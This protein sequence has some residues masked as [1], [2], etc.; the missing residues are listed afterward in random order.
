[1]AD[2]LED[3][4][5]LFDGAG[6]LLH[7]NPPAQA[8]LAPIEP[9]IP[10]QVPAW[11]QNCAP[12][13]T[14]AERPA[15]LP[16]A[17]QPL[18][19]ALQGDSLRHQG[20][21]CAAG[22]DAIPVALELTAKPLRNANPRQLTGVLIR[23]HWLEVRAA[24]ARG[25]PARQ[26]TA[27]A[28]PPFSREFLCRLL[29]ALP[30][31]LSVAEYGADQ[32]SARVVYVNSASLSITG[33]SLDE[34]LG[35]P[36]RLLHEDL[37][38]TLPA[39]EFD[40][41]RA[42]CRDGRQFE[43]RLP[44]KRKDGS[45][46]WNYTRLTSLRDDQG[47]VSHLLAL[48]DDISSVIKADT[49]LRW[50]RDQLRRVIEHLPAIFFAVG[51]QGD[52]RLFNQQL[53]A[54][55]GYERDDIRHMTLFDFF[56]GRSREE[57]DQAVATAFAKGLDF[58]LDL[59][60]ISHVGEQIPLTLYGAVA[61][62]GDTDPVLI[63]IALD[64]S[65]VRD[66]LRAS[67]ISE[68][69]LNR[70]QAFANIGL[71]DWNLRND[72]VYWSDRVPELIGST[73]SRMQFGFQEFLAAAHPLDRARLA[74]S[75]ENCVSGHD[76]LDEE[77]RIHRP[78]GSERWMLARANLIYDD[79][80]TPVRMLG[81]VQDITPLK[82]AEFIEKRAREEIQSI[83]DS[84]DAR[85]C[86]VDE[87]GEIISV[88]RSWQRHPY[89][90]PTRARSLASGGNYL[91]FC[92]SLA[93]AGR[94]DMARL[95][96]AVRSVL[97][98]T[99]GT[100]ETEIRVADDERDE[101]HLV[102][103]TPLR[104][105]SGEHPRVVINHTDVT[106]RRQIERDLRQAKDEAEQASR[107]KSEFLSLMSHE[108][109]TPMNAVLGF[110]QLLEQDEELNADQL[111]SVD[112]IL[113]AGRH[114][115]HLINEVL[116]LARVE[117]G[118]VT[119]DAE[120]IA[121]SDLVDECLPL[122]E[123]GA[124]QNDIRIKVG[125]MGRTGVIADRIRLKQVL[126]NLLSNAVKYNS[127]GGSVRIEAHDVEP[128][129][130]AATL[131]ET[132]VGETTVGEDADAK[133]P[134]V[135]IE[136]ID[137]G[138]GIAPEDIAGLFTP[139]SRLE[140]DTHREGTGIGLAVCRRLIEA[141]GGAI[142]ATS[143]LG[144]GSCFW[145]ELE[146]ARLAPEPQGSAPVR[147]SEH[148]LPR[149]PASLQ[150]IL[151]IEDNPSNLKLIERMLGRYASLRVISATNGAEGIELARRE[152]PDLILLDIHMAGMDGYEVF[153]RLRA[154]SRTSAIPV[155]AVTANATAEDI[156]QGNQAGFDAYLTKPVELPTL[157]EAMRRLMA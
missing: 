3:A 39:A 113:K 80:A 6:L 137:T 116:D 81:V 34:F 132:T 153:R 30:S 62:P 11:L 48:Q 43:V 124:R 54:V 90:H 130:M 73:V 5:L 118:R 109:R 97:Q 47:R 58:N 135:R 128:Q 71:W 10:G 119:L 69:R 31:G 36:C 89:R 92:D 24:R 133:E 138:L 18:A 8:L 77:F 26:A 134:R 125:S 156:A 142:G 115:L 136:V 88:N 14:P 122:V 35:H 64:V 85:I 9:P 51:A 78:D 16:A 103:I 106:R 123:A 107:A 93:E 101:I 105:A 145:M 126:I 22:P 41:L 55:S 40:E 50:E 129:K 131:A 155:I 75:I 53:C 95:A 87:N 117:S 1:L 29:E 67:A 147:E 42:A 37:S 56:A 38:A 102:R 82:H 72:E 79:R 99:A 59:P 104:G 49:R 52:F 44:D 70:S 23:L 96:S 4:L 149:L 27:A 32:H 98:G 110:A 114:L 150:R 143:E 141:M 108:L 66:T 57:L 74:T 7:A 127:P 84:L 60:L 111:E 152:Q 139:F 154:D 121:L 12:A 86:V 28:A 148:N 146:A 21:L 112:E 45:A 144:K 33:Y 15:P 68:E 25:A 20:Y 140:R 94:R 100:A 2:A 46:F 13:E 61:A 120:L 17:E 19:R 157:A 151:Q 76:V 63:G 91:D 65:N 83:I